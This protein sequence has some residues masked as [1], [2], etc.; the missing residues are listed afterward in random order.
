MDDPQENKLPQQSGGIRIKIIG[1]GNAGINAVDRLKLNN[2]GQVDLA[3]V[4]TDS[5]KLGNSPVHERVM[6]GR[7]V[8]RGMSSGGEAEVGRQAAESD[9]AQLEKLVDGVDLVFLLC[10]PSGG[11]GGG[12]TPLIAELAAQQGAI[13]ITFA[14]QPFT[15]EG[16]R[17][18]KQ[19]DEALTLLR[20]HCHAVIALPNDVLLQQVDEN[21]TVMEAF[22]VANEWV[23]RGV[24]AIWSMIFDEGL[25]NVDFATLRSAFRFRGGK[26]LF[27]TGRGEGEDYVNKALADLEVCPL[28]HLP[29]LRYTRKVD[30]LIVHINAGPELS[31]T[32]INQIMQTVSEK[33]GSRDNNVIGAVI[34]ENVHNS[35]TITVIGATDLGVGTA[36]RSSLRQT[37]RKLPDVS[38]L[39]AAPKP[40]AAVVDNG[41]PLK[42]MESK[43]SRQAPAKLQ[44]EFAFPTVEESRGFFE[45]SAPNNFEGGEDL[46]V[47]TFLRRGIKI[48]L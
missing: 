14:T 33:F 2:L 36:S 11:T 30:A 48:T 28:L 24:R 4:D 26:T 25:I 17:R 35:L 13:V 23:N 9:R 21:A 29:E 44:E 18:Q 7:S 45:K 40:E 34:D 16:A 46:D 37:V 22:E 31:L 6:I 42:R 41:D 39:A 27:G 20:E 12:A 5:E 43:N 32:Q 8:T 47:P 3:V 1:V 10:G 19:A 38:S 15:V